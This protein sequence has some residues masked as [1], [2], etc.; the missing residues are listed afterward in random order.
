MTQ[1]VYKIGDKV[2]IEFEILAFEDNYERDRRFAKSKSGITYCIYEEDI[3]PPLA[4]FSSGDPVECSL[5]SELWIKGK[6]IGMDKNYF[7]CSNPLV[8]YQS[9]RYCRK[10]QVSKPDHFANA[11]NPIDKFVTDEDG[12]RYKLVEVKDE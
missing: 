6:F 7:V 10:P 9:W 12:K 5:N 11:G 3:R 2:L 8:G 1:T 4:E